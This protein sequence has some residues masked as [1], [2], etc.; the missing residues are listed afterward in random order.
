MATTISA[1]YQ[2]TANELATLMQGFTTVTAQSS[3]LI[4][5]SALLG[6]QISGISQDFS[7]SS[8]VR[9]DDD[10]YNITPKKYPEF[11]IK[12]YT[13]QG[14]FIQPMMRKDVSFKHDLEKIFNSEITSAEGVREVLNR[15]EVCNSLLEKF[16]VFLHG[17]N[18]HIS[19]IHAKFAN[20]ECFFKTPPNTFLISNFSTEQLAPYGGNVLSIFL[21]ASAIRSISSMTFSKAMEAYNAMFPTPSAPTSIAATTPPT[22]SYPYASRT[23]QTI[24]GGSDLANKISPTIANNI[25]IGNFNIVKKTVVEFETKIRIDD[26]VLIKNLKNLIKKDIDINNPMPSATDISSDDLILELKQSFPNI[27][28]YFYTDIDLSF[29]DLTCEFTDCGDIL[30]SYY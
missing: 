5:K 22:T 25:M 21:A 11:D 14:N 27:T 13:L 29:D 30:K 26:I 19:R 15:L 18:V 24:F 12:M 23:L 6:D 3:A 16:A 7:S 10:L 8:M 1:R 20:D 17:L 9:N 2:N 28:E 4:E